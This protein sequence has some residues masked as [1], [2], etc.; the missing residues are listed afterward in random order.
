LLDHQGEDTNVGARFTLRRECFRIKAPV[1]LPD[2]EGEVLS[3]EVG[4][5]VATLRLNLELELK[6][7]Y[8]ELT[9][10]WEA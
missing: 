6:T 1:A 3:A 8:P 9:L 2:E 4:D 5:L 7:L 10:E